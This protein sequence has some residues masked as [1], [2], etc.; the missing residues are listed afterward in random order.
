MLLRISG[1][2]N[3]SSLSV[4]GAKELYTCFILFFYCIATKLVKLHLGIYHFHL[5]V[6]VG[7]LK[8]W[9]CP[10]LHL[11]LSCDKSTFY[12]PFIL[13]PSLLFGFLKPGLARR[14]NAKFLFASTSEIYGG[15]PSRGLFS[16]ITKQFFPILCDFESRC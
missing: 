10:S 13:I 11:F 15:M 3:L 9:V 16:H 14:T 4:L 6:T 12:A 7:R 8:Y 5:F 2:L 1:I